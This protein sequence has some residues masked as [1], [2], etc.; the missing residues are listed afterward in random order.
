MSPRQRR[1][2]TVWRV[3]VVLAIVMAHPTVVPAQ[4]NDPEPLVARYRVTVVGLSANDSGAVREQEWVFARQ[5]DRVAI[6]K[7]ETEEVWRRQPNGAVSLQRVLHAQQRVIDY[8]AGELAALG[9]EVDWSALERWSVAGDGIAAERDAT[10]QLPVRWAQRIGP[11]AAARFELIDWQR[12]TQT[13]RS[14]SGE[15]S[16]GYLHIDAADF[17]DM[18]YDPAVRAAEAMDVRAGWRQVHRH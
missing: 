15:R 14:L 16:A 4:A 2:G 5:P 8:S 11:H 17:G 9:V 3:A 12:G 10:V 13:N 18:P 6:D 7:G 1:F